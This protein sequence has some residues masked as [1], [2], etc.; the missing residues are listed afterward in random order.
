MFCTGQER[1]DYLISNGNDW[2]KEI[3]FAAQNLENRIRS[4]NN[5]FLGLDHDPKAKALFNQHWRTKEHLYVFLNSY[6]SK[7]ASH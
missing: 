7:K 1:F 5:T 6:P 3:Y 2:W 4:K